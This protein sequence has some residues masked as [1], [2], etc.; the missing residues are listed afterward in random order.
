MS[1]ACSRRDFLKKLY[2]AIL[3][4]GAAS[5]ISFE[6]LLAADRQSP[7]ARANLLWLHGASCSGCSVSLLNVEQVP[8]VDVVTRFANI[9]YHTDLSAATGHQVLELLE[10]TLQG[11]QPFV[12]VLEGG[13]PAGMP[14]ACL[15][16]GKPITEWVERLASK[17]MACIAAG[18]CASMG[19]VAAMHGMLTGSMT[20]PAFL[21]QR[22]INK[23]VVSLPGCPMKPE[24][25]LYTLLHAVSQRGLPP[26][27]TLGRPRRFY[28]HTVHERCIYYADFQEGHFAQHI[29]E[30]GCLL[31]LGC[32]G[33]ITH[34]D[35]PT[36]G[37]NGN[38]NH[39]IRA[40]HPCIGC[41]SDQFPRRIMLHAYQDPRLTTDHAASWDAPAG[42]QTGGPQS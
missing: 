39:C 38:T 41:A 16:G 30:E 37:H 31:H 3:V 26:L 11:D 15:L 40:G 5:F 34:F 20:L 36:Q 32:Q 9:I 2:Q 18:T 10:H 33:P 14:H 6:D 35:C 23:P 27:D 13:I 8:V 25:L 21:A 19:G 4:S 42:A 17:A 24:H 7:S 29:G 12:F 1:E 22:K 28:Q